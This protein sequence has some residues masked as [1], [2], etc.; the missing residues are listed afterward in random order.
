MTTQ[1]PVDPTDLAQWDDD[2]A[3][4]EVQPNQFDDVPDG[5]YQ[6]RVEKVE[7]SRTQA[8][9]PMLKWQ[10]RILGPQHAGRMLFRNNVIASRENLK[11]LKADLLVCGLE[12]GKL[13]DLGSRLGELLDVALEVTRKTRGEYANVYLNKRIVL[14]DPDGGYRDAAKGALSAF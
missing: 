5:K 8:G 6:A 11:F 1:T 12:L 7:L 9:D 14:D 10:L 2:Y 13:S 3:A 4:A